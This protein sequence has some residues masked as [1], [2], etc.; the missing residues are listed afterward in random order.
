MLDVEK[1]LFIDFQKIRVQETQSELVRGS[2]PRS[3]EVILRAE[4]VET[5]QVW[6]LL[7]NSNLNVYLSIF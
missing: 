2:I 3:L 6:V 1:S 7:S 4:I 5:V